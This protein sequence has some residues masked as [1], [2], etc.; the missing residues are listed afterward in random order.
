M[1][2]YY[3]IVLVLL[4]PRGWR[5]SW[6]FARS[7]SQQTH[8]NVWSTT[9]YEALQCPRRDSYFDL[10]DPERIEE[11]EFVLYHQEE[12]RVGFAE[13]HKAADF[14]QFPFYRPRLFRFLFKS[15]LYAEHIQYTAKGGVV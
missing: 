9:L 3:I 4:I 11:T 15:V 8:R 2:F 7:T 13:K 5:G 6:P 10:Q 1:Q 14:L 12:P